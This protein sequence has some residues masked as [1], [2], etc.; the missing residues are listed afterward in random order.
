MQ[1]YVVKIY[2]WWFENVDERTSG[3]P[4]QRMFGILKTLNITMDASNLARTTQVGVIHSLQHF[5]FVTGL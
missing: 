4:P 3:T 2:G 5:S 1:L